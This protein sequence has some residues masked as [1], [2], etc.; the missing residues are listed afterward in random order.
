MAKLFDAL[1]NDKQNQGCNTLAISLVP[2]ADK[3]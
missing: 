1:L 3:P 2:L